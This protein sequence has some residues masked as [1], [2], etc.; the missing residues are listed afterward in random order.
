MHNLLGFVVGA[1]AA[2]VVYALLTILWGDEGRS[3][4]SVLVDAA[5]FTAI[6]LVLMGIW[7]WVSSRSRR[8]AVRKRQKSQ[9]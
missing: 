2:F 3:V 7:D 8:A 6:W 5:K 1:V 9:V 4:S